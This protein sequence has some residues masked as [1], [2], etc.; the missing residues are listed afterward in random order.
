MEKGRKRGG[1]CPSCGGELWPGARYCH[2][3]GAPAPSPRR[4]PRR[5]LGSLL[6]LSLVLGTLLFFLPARSSPN[7]S[8]F[9]PGILYPPQGRTVTQGASV[10]PGQPDEGTG[11]SVLLHLGLSPSASQQTGGGAATGQPGLVLSQRL[12]GWEWTR[13][14]NDL[15]LAVATVEYTLLNQGTAQVSG[16]ELVLGERRWEAPPLSPGQEYRGTFTLETLPVWSSIGGSPFL[17]GFEVCSD[18]VAE[19]SGERV[20]NHLSA[21]IPRSELEMDPSYALYLSPYLVTPGDPVIRFTLRELLE[22]KP[23]WDLRPVED[24]LADWVGGGITGSDPGDVVRYDFGKLDAERWLQEHGF[25]SQL[26]RETIASRRGVCID[27]AILYAT[28]LRAWGYGPEDVYV[29][30]GIPMQELQEASGSEVV[31]H[32][33][34]VYRKEILGQPIWVLAE[35]TSGGI[36][37]LVT[38]VVGPLW[39]G[40]ME[41]IG[42]EGLK[43]YGGCYAFND[44]YFRR[45]EGGEFSNLTG[46][47][48]AH[49]GSVSAPS[50]SREESGAAPEGLAGQVQALVDSLR[51]PGLPKDQ[52]KGCKAFL[53][54]Y[55]VDHWH[56]EDPLKEGVENPVNLLLFVE[57]ETKEESKATIVWLFGKMGYF[58]SPAGSLVREVDEMYPAKEE[59]EL[60]RKFS[61]GANS[62]LQ[63]HMKCMYVRGT[64]FGHLW[65]VSGHLEYADENPLNHLRGTRITRELAE[66]SESIVWPNVKWESFEEDVRLGLHALGY[67]DGKVGRVG[68]RVRWVENIRYGNGGCFEGEDEYHYNDGVLRTVILLGNGVHA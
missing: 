51:K 47:P 59:V 34:V 58:P 68:S 37:R 54:D 62:L 17:T 52:M 1:R 40:L 22:R 18:L 45:L 25:W 41:A 64:R 33:W 9:S 39:D 28:L 7:T 42:R 55:Y 49:R 56:W 27:Q 24:Y 16:L 12:E 66:A 21:F 26:P 65:A 67:Y 13:D 50:L 3:C 15:P 44:A 30:C 5:L 46:S 19:W 31:G 2:R 10:P 63:F 60:F 20:A 6:I 57:G 35:V 43:L 61:V 48:E 4:A 53:L 38:E 32:A 8:R 29:V 11:A 14:E 36:N 23:R